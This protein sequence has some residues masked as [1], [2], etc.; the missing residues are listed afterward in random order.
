MRKLIISLCLVVGGG[1]SATALA[2]CG[3]DDA[4]GPDVAR[5]AEATAKK[6]TARIAMRISVEGAGLPLPIAIDAKG[7]MALNA[8]K[9]RVTFDLASLLGLAGAPQGT[10]GELEMRFGGGTVYAKPP[11][12]DQLEIPGGKPWVSLELPKLAGA[13]GLP[14]RGLGKLFTLEPAAQLRALKAAKNLKEVGKED[15]GG[16]QTTHYRG[17]LRLSDF[18]ATLAPAER[19][20]VEKGI[21]RLEQLGGQSNGNL[22]EPVPVDL[23]IDED[24]VTRKMLAETKL[25]AQNGQPGGTIKQSYVLSDFGVVLDAE[26]PAAQDTYDATEALAGV[27]KQVATMGSGGTATP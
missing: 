17:T 23:W 6:G 16:A 13:L 21:K 18:A 15:V 3:T 11:K 1:V 7:V 19:A 10:P 12:L 27:L 22:D 24:G 2:G 9:G 14:T 8:A 4:V 25:P 20:E 5:A 26:P